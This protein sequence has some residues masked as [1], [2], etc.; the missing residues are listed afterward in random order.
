MGDRLGTPGA[1]V[2]FSLRPPAKQCDNY[3]WTLFTGLF[4]TELT[5]SAS[6]T[7][8]QL[9][10]VVFSTVYVAS[11]H[12][13]RESVGGLDKDLCSMGAQ[14]FSASLLA[15]GVLGHSLGAFRHGVFGQLSGQE[16]AHSGLNLPTGDGG[17]L[18]VVGQT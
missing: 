11:C 4:Q 12:F 10:A 8:L 16:Q 18:V 13:S 14:S 15:A 9:Q 6:F 1:V 5:H 7:F 2:S 3:L 17:S